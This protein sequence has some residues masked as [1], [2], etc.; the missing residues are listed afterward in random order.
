MNNIILFAGRAN[1]GL[2]KAIAQDLN[3]PLGNCTAQQFPDGEVTVQLQESVRR[4]SVFIV[5]STSPPVNDHLMELLAF[6]DACRRTAARQITAIIPYFGYARAD[7]R[8]GRSEPITASMVA[9][10]MQTVGINRVITLDLHAPQIEGFFRIPVDSL[11]AVSI[12]GET[13]RDRLPADVVVVSPDTGRVSM[14]TDYAQI[15]DTSV[16]VVHKQRQNGTQTQ[17][18]RIVGQV[19]DRPCLIIDDM[20]S[21]GGTI[22]KTI[23]ALL[24][25]GARPEMTV[26]VTHGLFIQD[27]RQKLSHDSIQQILA[28][29]T[30]S[31]NAENWSQLQIVSVAPLIAQM[32]RKDE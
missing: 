12:L 4:K 10:I 26:A 27:A 7:K 5:Q 14:A 18:T 19:R 6:A 2:A 23:D 11:S 30:I 8:H 13:L 28:T 15:L 25:A 17:V 22:A 3:I 32:I 1:P 31:I 29:D 9:E 21:T 20:I 24:D 16:I